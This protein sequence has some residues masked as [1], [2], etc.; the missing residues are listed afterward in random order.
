MASEIRSLGARSVVLVGPTPKWTGN[1]PAIMA[2]EYWPELPEWIS[3]N[4]VE[5]ERQVDKELQ[6]RYGAS[7]KLRYVSLF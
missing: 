6:R 3:D 5:E 1:L 7:T 2:A 4:M